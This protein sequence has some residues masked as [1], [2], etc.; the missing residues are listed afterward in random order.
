ML[1]VHRGTAR[2]VGLL[3][4]EHER[5]SLVVHP[6]QFRRVLGERAGIR[7]DG[8]HPFSGVARD[9]HRQRPAL[10]FRSIEAR[11]QRLR[12]RSKLVSVQHVMDACHRERIRPVDGGDPRGGI[13]T[14]HQRDMPRPGKHHVRGEAAFARDEAA[15]FTYPAVG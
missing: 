2:R 15:I 6:D 14:T 1:R 5:Q 11:Q 12:R 3:P 4:I 7:H 13:G 10:H 9:I 8:G